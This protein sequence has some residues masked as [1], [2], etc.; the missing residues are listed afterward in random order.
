[1]AVWVDTRSYRLK[2]APN[3]CQ[4]RALLR[5]RGIKMDLLAMSSTMIAYK[6]FPSTTFKGPPVHG[7]LLIP[8]CRN[9][10]ALTPR[11]HTGYVYVTTSPEHTIQS[12][13]RSS[14]GLIPWFR[15]GRLRYGDILRDAYASCTMKSTK[16]CTVMKASSSPAHR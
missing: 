6:F 12:H 15:Y 14:M 11:Q 7:H 4:Y 2:I 13:S 8:W 9:R 16:K 5:K 1:M 3:A 10:G